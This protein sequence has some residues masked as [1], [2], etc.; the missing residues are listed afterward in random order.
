MKR[1]KTRENNNRVYAAVHQKTATYSLTCIKKKLERGYLLRFM[2]NRNICCFIGCSFSWTA[3]NNLFSIFYLK[4]RPPAT[5]TKFW[6]IF[7]I[8]SRY[9]SS[10]LLLHYPQAFFIFFIFSKYKVS[11]NFAIFLN[12]NSTISSSSSQNTNPWNFKQYTHEIS[13]RQTPSSYCLR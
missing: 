11:R 10:F 7:F 6:T 13:T 8:F 2:K 12:L 3:A 4:N 1:K 5:L 9:H